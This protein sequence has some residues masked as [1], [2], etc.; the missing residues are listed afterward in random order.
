MLVFLQHKS[1]FSIVTEMSCFGRLGG[2]LRGK[3]G[4]IFVE[5]ELRPFH[6][7]LSH[8]T[9][10]P[11]AMINSSKR[12]ST[13]EKAAAKEQGA[14]VFLCHPIILLIYSNSKRKCVWSYC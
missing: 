9:N 13:S 6:A 3:S 11:G 10:A 5:I 12:R 7:Q 1:P 2:L 8:A 4:S 14:T